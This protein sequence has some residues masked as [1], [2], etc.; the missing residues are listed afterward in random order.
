MCNIQQLTNI[1]SEYQ[2]LCPLGEGGQG[3]VY[4]GKYKD[5]DVAIKL[6]HELSD[7]KRIYRE[8]D[9]LNNN[10]NLH[11]IKIISHCEIKFSK[12]IGLLV[13]YEYLD[14]GDLTKYLRNKDVLDYKKILLIGH[15]MCIAI[16]ELWK[17]RIVHRDIKPANIVEKDNKHYVLV[18]I[19]LAKYLDLSNITC[20]GHRVGTRGYMSPEQ[21]KGHNSLTIRSDIFSLGVTLFELATKTHPFSRDQNLIGTKDP[22]RISNFRNDI[23][24]DF[25]N[26]LNKMMSSSIK[27]RPVHIQKE[28]ENLLNIK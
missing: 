20:P 9:F 21:A 27:Y 8:I 4:K 25:E 19:G 2:L 18:D 16:E 10:N 23:P 17:N 11:I 28:F 5:I 15:Q 1:P 24:D 13:A 6:F 12:D 14:G 3:S 26:L 22:Y 7:K